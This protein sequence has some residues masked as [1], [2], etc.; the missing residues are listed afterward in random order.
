MWNGSRITAALMFLAV[1]RAVSAANSDL[2]GDQA[3]I[4]ESVRTSA[5]AYSDRLPDFICTQMTHRETTG[6]GHAAS[7]FAG[8]DRGNG[9]SDVIE[10]RL[11]YY[12]KKES[13]EVVSVDGKKAAGLDRTELYGAM[14]GGEFGS[15]LRE[16]F[17]PRSQAT[18]TWVKATKVN[19]RSAYVFGFHVPAA[20][21]ATVTHRET[22]QE[23]V[24]AF[25]GEIAVDAESLEVLRIHSVLEL[26]K[27]FPV[28][29]SEL[30]IVYQ[31]VKIAGKP[32][33]LPAHSEVRVKDAAHMFVNRIDFTGYRRFA[34]ES[35]IHYDAPPQ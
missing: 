7:D 6:A 15:T 19:G 14:S 26:P 23:I 22:N 33:L 9:S 27:T 30:T 17:N 11:T 12:G 24:V 18:F 32:Y 3:R 35:T 20:N 25:G 16:I 8:T 10:E 28:E 34:T 1:A 4:I 21:G 5:L 13:Y 29:M 31:T 2:T